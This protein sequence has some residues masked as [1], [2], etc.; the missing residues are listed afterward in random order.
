[1]VELS[2]G[3]VD[4][5]SIGEVCRSGGVGAKSRPEITVHFNLFMYDALHCSMSSRSSGISATV[6]AV[7]VDM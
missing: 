2:D 1:M 4:D 6:D 3:F 7:I 5:E